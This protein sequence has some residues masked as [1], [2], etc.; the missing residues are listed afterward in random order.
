MGV[1]IHYVQR[2]DD[3]HVCIEVIQCVADCAPAQ[4]G[5]SYSSEGF[6]AVYAGC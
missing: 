1:V 4:C 5:S 6:K 2:E 3:A